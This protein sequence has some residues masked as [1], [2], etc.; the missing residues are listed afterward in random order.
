MANWFET[1]AILFVL[2][3]VIA[4]GSILCVL[5]CEPVL[6]A[7]GLQQRR[8]AGLVDRVERELV[9]L[10]GKQVK[11]ALRSAD[12]GETRRSGRDGE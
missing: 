3:L 1:M 5:A 11:P 6:A 4:A 8:L 9:V 12:R 2:A 7:L 10:L